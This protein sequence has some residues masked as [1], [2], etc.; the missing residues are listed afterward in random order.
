MAI[1]H[2]KGVRPADRFPRQRQIDPRPVARDANAF[3]QG[4]WAFAA[5]VDR[6][7]DRPFVVYLGQ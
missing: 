4:N 1:G 5:A 6:L 2:K 7:E 3:A